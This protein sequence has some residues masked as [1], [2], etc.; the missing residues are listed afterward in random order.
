MSNIRLFPADWPQRFTITE[1]N[2]ST[3]FS[4]LGLGKI[5]DAISCT[6]TE[7]RNGLFELEMQY[8]VTG[9]RYSQLA[10]RM[11][12]VAPPNPY[13]DPQAF[14]IYSIS[15]QYGGKVKIKAQHIS[16]DLS[17]VMMK[18]GE[19]SDDA[20]NPSK[21]W[22]YVNSHLTNGFSLNA[23]NTDFQYTF[24]SD[25][26]INDAIDD[27]DGNKTKKWVLKGPK[28][29]RNILMGNSE[30][31]L[32]KLYSVENKTG[33]EPEFRFNNFVISLNKDR[34][35][36]RGIRIKYGKNM[37]GFTQEESVEKIY[38]HVYPFYYAS[39]IT[40][41]EGGFADG[42]QI[43]L[44]DWACDLTDWTAWPSQTSG[45]YAYDSANPA[46]IDTGLRDDDGNKM[47]FKNILPLDISSLYKGDYGINLEEL[48]QV[49]RYD[50]NCGL[51]ITSNDDG[52][53][54]FSKDE[55]V[56]IGLGAPIGDWALRRLSRKMD[57][58]G[59]YMFTKDDLS[60][61]RLDDYGYGFSMAD[62][63][64][65]LISHGWAPDYAIVQVSG[66]VTNNSG[67]D[68]SYSELGNMDMFQ[69]EGDGEVWNAASYYY[70]LTKSEDVSKIAARIRK[71]TLR[72]IQEN[73]LSRFPVQL[74][75]DMALAE[76]TNIKS[77]YD[78]RLCDTIMVLYPSFNVTT[79]AKCTKTTYN[80][81]TDKYT[82][83]DF[84]NSWSGLAFRTSQNID[85]TKRSFASYN[86]IDAK[87]G[88]IRFLAGG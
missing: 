86:Y 72:Y 84:S 29:V 55:T 73:H 66:K 16:Y 33:E 1:S 2:N 5:T 54:K 37:K 61:F 13:D 26:T 40:Y 70:D 83:L 46:L 76:P 15:K 49:S 48:G 64:S 52:N 36:N 6:V 34:G 12:I 45:N 35:S 7:E 24:K 31:G 88:H 77:L 75:V 80:C 87:F 20:L 19:I 10:V 57:Q 79:V 22:S 67:Q 47:P 78:I 51:H 82:K 59:Q 4:G 65:I 50:L 11:L 28:S 9:I 81:L 71:P 43:T 30:D 41:Y 39:S 38:T 63:Y 14:R 21:I 60:H 44:N 23:A 69:L 42:N 18:K 53:N 32:T 8:P 3:I 74:T 62:D 17:N 85:S 58:F 25:L 68:W 56:S 27:S